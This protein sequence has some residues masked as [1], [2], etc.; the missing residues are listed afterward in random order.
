MMVVFSGYRPIRGLVLAVHTI[1][2]HAILYC[3]YVMRI[4]LV[5]KTSL[6]Y[7]SL[8]VHLYLQWM[9]GTRDTSI[10]KYCIYF[11][12]GNTLAHAKP[13]HTNYVSVH[14]LCISVLKTYMCKIEEIYRCTSPSYDGVVFYKT[15][16]LGCL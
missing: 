4:T 2:A 7:F 12:Y 15:A 6:E 13:R 10:R 16:V 11:A 9:A 1:T 8:P 14:L 3:F 5:P